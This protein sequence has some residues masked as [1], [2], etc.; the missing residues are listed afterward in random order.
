MNWTPTFTV[1]PWILRPSSL[2]RTEGFFL[3][4]IN[5]FLREGLGVYERRRPEVSSR[6][7]PSEIGTDLG[8]FTKG[9]ERVSSDY[10]E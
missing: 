4:L 2:Y 3:Q 8:T 10:H 1:S 6:T 5:R 7:I 9:L